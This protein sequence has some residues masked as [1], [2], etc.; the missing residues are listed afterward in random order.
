MTTHERPV[1]PGLFR[2]E[3]EP[4]LIAAKC[5]SCGTVTFP[6]PEGCPRCTSARLDDHVLP[7]T[8]L[9]W[10]WTVQRFEPKRPYVAA[11]SGEFVP[12]GVGYV[13][14]PGECIV[15]GRL[16]TTDPARLR[17]GVPCRTAVAEAW[18]DA[19]GTRVLTYAFEPVEAS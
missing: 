16:T 3:D 14:F 8:G 17:L 15:E 12:Y 5:A 9:L 13:E 6:A 18:V 1:A 19:D 11:A 10:S 2:L 7:G 4:C